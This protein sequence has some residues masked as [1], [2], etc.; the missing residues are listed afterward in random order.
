MLEMMS[1]GNFSFL[2]DVHEHPDGFNILAVSALPSM[3][4]GYAGYF[5]VWE[6]GKI[7]ICD[8][9]VDVHYA[10]LLPFQLQKGVWDVYFARE[11]SPTGYGGTWS[12]PC[13]VIIT[14]ERDAPVKCEYTN[15]GPEPGENGAEAQSWLWSWNPMIELSER[16]NRKNALQTSSI[17]SGQMGVISQEAQTVINTVIEG[18]SD[19]LQQMYFTHAAAEEYF[20][21]F[22]Y[23][24]FDFGPLPN[25]PGW[26]QYLSFLQK[27][28]PDM[29]WTALE[30]ED[31]RELDDELRYEEYLIQ[32]HMMV[33]WGT[34]WGDGIYPISVAQDAKQ[35]VRAIVIQLDML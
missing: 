23:G 32:R 18:K 1:T 29:D 31:A 34:T 24:A 6:S 15:I 10:E 5:R 7:S 2:W 25:Q 14:Q 20:Q 33:A 11:Y 16:Q 27:A 8:P 30:Q 13:F 9:Y 21:Q 22:D 12:A 17:K 4:I 28:N 19:R 3:N 35:Q 26:Q